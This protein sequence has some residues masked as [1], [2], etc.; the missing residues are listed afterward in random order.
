M[1]EVE[2]KKLADEVRVERKAG[3]PKSIKVVDDV[4]TAGVSEVKMVS[5]PKAV[6]NMNAEP[7][8]QDTAMAR[9]FAFKPSSDYK[10][11]VEISDEDAEE[12]GLAG[13]LLG[14]DPKR[15]IALLAKD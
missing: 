11:W 8:K 6:G 3:R 4:I 5:A 14:H 12:L 13:K 15:K 2:S 1:N 9:R 10:N 7:A